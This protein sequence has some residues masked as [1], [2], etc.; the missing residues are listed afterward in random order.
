[1]A[2]RFLDR[3]GILIVLLSGLSLAFLVAAGISLWNPPA[4]EAVAAIPDGTEQQ[5][6]PVKDTV[7]Q[8]PFQPAEFVLEGEDGVSVLDLLKRDHKVMLD[9]ELMI[10]GSIVLAIDS[11]MAQ[12]DEVWVYYQDSIPGSTSP[13][14]CITSTGETIRWVLKRRR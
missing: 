10:F 13:D 3:E 14:L 7:T 8:P 4:E 9:S 5:A 6:A 1:M 11:V 12:P 2:Q